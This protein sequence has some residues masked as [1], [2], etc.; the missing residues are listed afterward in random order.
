VILGRHGLW[1][2]NDEDIA[3][4][5]NVVVKQLLGLQINAEKYYFGI[6]KSLVE[7]DEVLEV[8][9]KHVY[10]LRQVIL[11]GDSESCSDQIFQ[12]MQAVAD[13][14]VLHNVDP[15]KPPKTWNL[16]K[17][18][19]EFVGL[20]G[21]LLGGNMHKFIFSECSYIMDLLISKMLCRI[22]QGHPRGKPTI[23]T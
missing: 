18:L 11:S 19:D 1:I 21:K 9:R 13:E 5:S 23:S 12:Y 7:F 4:E 10:N 22:I 6:R 17:L 3:I 15:Q 14:I 8:Q 16:A 2:T 20:G